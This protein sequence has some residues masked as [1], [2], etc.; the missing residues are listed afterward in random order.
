MTYMPKP[1]DVII[2]TC[3]IVFVVVAIFAVLDLIGVIRIP[4]KGRG[5]ILFRVLIIEIILVGVGV[6]GGMLKIRDTIPVPD[7]AE[8]RADN[9]PL[10]CLL[11]KET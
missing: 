1:Y 7:Q 9:P 8:C 4:D 10:G 11:R 5:K 3:T 2:W 6:F